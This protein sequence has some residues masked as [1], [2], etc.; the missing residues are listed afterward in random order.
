MRMPAPASTDAIPTEFLARTAGA[1]GLAAL[2]VIHVVDLPGTLDETPLIGYG[3]L[4]LI[5]AAIVGAAALISVAGRVTWAFADL[6][7]TGALVAYV[8]S[9]TTGLPTDADDIGNWKCSLGIAALSV[10][11]LL[12]LLA[13]WR[14]RPQHRPPAPAAYRDVPGDGHLIGVTGDAP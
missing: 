7:A 11:G 5:A 8:L 13:A 2:A 1:V 10:E 3:Y 14:M 4:V 9:R 12:V 6:I